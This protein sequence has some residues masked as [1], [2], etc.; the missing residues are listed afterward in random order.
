MKKTVAVL[1]TVFNRKDITLKGLSTLYAAMKPVEDKYSFDVY[2]T[3]DGCTDGTPEAVKKCFPDVHIINADGNLYWSGGMRK[4]WDVSSKT[5]DYDYYLWFNDDAVLYENAL[6]ILFSTEESY[7]NSIIVG[8]MCSSNDKKKLCYGG[9]DLDKKL[10]D[11]NDSLAKKC[12]SFNGNL[13]LIPSFAFK[14]LGTISKVYSHSFGDFDYGYRA[15]KKKIQMYIC[16]GF[17]GIC[18]RHSSLPIWCNPNFKL[19]KRIKN[20]YSPL[21]NP[22]REAFHFDRI[23]KGTLIALMHIIT[24]HVR[25]LFPKIW[26][27]N[28]I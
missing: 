8:N 15:Y 7:S 10:V 4:A 16:P 1:L 27:I 2:M 9:R 19:A 5:H 13:V 6:Q 20:Y 17:Q 28:I 12:N 3:N 23:H 11:I 18:N 24:N 21:G 22:P 26:D 25:L 14:K